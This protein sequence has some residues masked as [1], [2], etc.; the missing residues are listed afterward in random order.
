MVRKSKLFAV[1]CLIGISFTGFAENQSLLIATN[2]T[3]I[4]SPGLENFSEEASQLQNVLDT[5]FKGQN[6][7]VR[8]QFIDPAPYPDYIQWLV[9]WW[10][11]TFPEEDPP[12][13]IEI[14]FSKAEKSNQWLYEGIKIEN[15]TLKEKHL[16]PKV[17]T[18]VEEHIIQEGD[19]EKQI[20]KK[21]LKIL[22]QALDQ[23]WLQALQQE[24]EAFALRKEY[25]RSYAGFDMN[26][27][28][29]FPYE[30]DNIL[31]EHMEDSLLEATFDDSVMSAQY[32]LMDYEDKPSIIKDNQ[33][34]KPDF[35]HT[36]KNQVE[37]YNNLMAIVN[38]LKDYNYFHERDK[39]SDWPNT[40][41]KKWVLPT[42]KPAGFEDKTDS[43]HKLLMVK[44]PTLK[45]N[46]FMPDMA[47]RQNYGEWKA[48]R[49]NMFAKDFSKTYLPNK[50]VPWGN[51]WL[52]AHE[53]YA[54]L[55]SRE[56]FL[57]LTWKEAWDYVNAGFPVYFVFPKLNDAGHIAIGYPSVKIKSK[58]D[59]G[60]KGYIV[61]AGKDSGK[62]LIKAGFGAFT[63]D[64]N[65]DDQIRIYLYLG[66]LNL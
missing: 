8:V 47:W 32:I 54:L 12:Q 62:V 52:R 61:Q 43:I 27:Y 10:A 2:N 37:R 34:H 13:D 60:N 41:H 11:E 4:P 58:I 19:D 64:K 33:L 1:I 7:T 35:D 16:L 14:L 53:I 28:E 15:R 65:L 26:Y 50:A 6:I 46:S 42:A 66:Y 39:V 51:P 55:P 59:A 57:E 44:Q 23:R 38:T 36:D 17:M 21:W 9:D 40:S 29:F 48:T 31:Y 56:D 20:V 30:K 24:G 5:Y 25:D 18:Y 49:C 45:K 3:E 22:A 63:T